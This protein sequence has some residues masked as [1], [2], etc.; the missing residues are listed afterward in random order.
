[1]SCRKFLV[2]VRLTILKLNLSEH[3]LISIRKVNALLT[4]SMEI[5]ESLYNLNSQWDWSLIPIYFSI[6]R[7][8]TEVSAAVIRDKQRCA[9]VTCPRLKS[10]QNR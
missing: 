4:V 6:V 10:S 3:F 8:K 7:Y 9:K 2:P 1:M 5:I